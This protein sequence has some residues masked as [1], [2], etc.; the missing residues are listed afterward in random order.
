[1]IVLFGGEKGGTGKSTLAT[2]FSISCAIQGKDTIIVDCDPQITATRWVERRR[3]HFP[4]LPQVQVIQKTGNVY[5]T[6]LDLGKKYEMVVID[7]GGRDSE[8]LRTAMVIA[9]VMYIPLKASQPDL[10]T[11]KHMDQLVKLAK[12]LNQKLLTRLILSM[13]STNPI[14]TEDK[15]AKELLSKIPNIL[16]SEIIIRERKAY[17]DA[18]ADG[19]GVLELDN[20]K[21]ANEIKKL[22]EEI[23]NEGK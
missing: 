5:E 7:A 21:A 13:A 1:M 4:D 17:R 6:V 11:S 8:E 14:L 12:G 15:E 23:L 3:K 22:Y 10:E 19:R 16:V 2:N 18:I 9:D 20:A